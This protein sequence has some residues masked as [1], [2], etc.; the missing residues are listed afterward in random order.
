MRTKM[1]LDP[2]SLT[3]VRGVLEFLLEELESNFV[4]TYDGWG[5]HLLTDNFSGLFNQDFQDLFCGIR[6]EFPELRVTFGFIGKAGFDNLKNN[7]VLHDK[8]V[9]SVKL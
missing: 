9:F 7:S 1:P 6:N 4:A 2:T 8:K 5:W 3:T